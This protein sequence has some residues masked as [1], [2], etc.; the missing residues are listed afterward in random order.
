[1]ILYFL[2]AFASW[3]EILTSYGPVKLV[4]V[5]KLRLLCLGLSK[6]YHGD[7]Q[8][9]QNTKSNKKPFHTHASSSSIDFGAGPFHVDQSNSYCCS[10]LLSGK[11]HHF[12]SSDK[13]GFHAR[14]NDRSSRTILRASA[15]RGDHVFSFP[16]HRRPVAPSRHYCAICLSSDRRRLLRSPARRRGTGLPMLPGNPQ[17]RP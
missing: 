4:F 14:A 1:M 10:F 13:L 8:N 11:N 5:N 16:C 6:C 15:F 7:E 12:P 3:R 2:C 9:A 17:G